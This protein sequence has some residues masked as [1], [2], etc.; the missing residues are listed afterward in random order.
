MALLS[1][2]RRRSRVACRPAAGCLRRRRCGPGRTDDRRP[3]RPV[4]GRLAAAP[5]TSTHG[6]AVHHGSIS[7]QRLVAERVDPRPGAER[8]PE[9]HV[10]ALHPARHA[11]GRDAGDLRHLADRLPPGQVV[12][13]RR[14]GSAAASSGSVGQPV[15]HLP[16]QPGRL[17]P[18]ARARSPAGRSGRTAS[19]TACRRPAAGVVSTTSGRPHGQRW[20]TARVPR[21]GRP[22]CAATA[23]RSASVAGCA[24]AGV[25]NPPPAPAVVRRH[26]PP[27]LVGGSLAGRSASAA[28]TLDHS[29]SYQGS[30]R[31]A[32]PASA[33]AGVAGGAV[34]VVRA[35]TSR[36]LARARPCR[37]APGPGSRCTPGPAT[38]AASSD[39]LADPLPLGGLGRLQPRDLGLLVEVDP[40]RVG[41][42]QGERDQ[43]RE[44]H[45]GPAGE[46]P[47]LRVRWCRLAAPPAAGTPGRGRAGSRSGR[48]R[49]RGPAP[50]RP[51]G[52][53][54]GSARRRP[55]GPSRPAPAGRPAGR[56]DPAA[57]ARR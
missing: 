3:G 20:A 55:R 49:C 39:E 18:A 33:L 29:V 45:G 15:G 31:P 41:V 25:R 48:R 7:A 19:G 35:R 40:H 51:A 13:V 34:R 47:G 14:P 56:A 6:P 44:Q 27:A 23:A 54:R 57:R 12:L 50:R 30:A 36:R 10:Q 52:G 32:S 46:P 26:G 5:G 1:S 28:C 24:P 22:S 11:A 42:G 38:C 43:H 16:H 53:A 17:Q 37:T 8:V 4:S 21:G 2:R 9:V